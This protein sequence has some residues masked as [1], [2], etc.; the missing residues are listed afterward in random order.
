MQEKSSDDEI[1]I[2]TNKSVKLNSKK[3]GSYMQLWI[4][5]AK[6]SRH[7]IEI[8]FDLLNN[9]LQEFDASIIKGSEKQHYIIT[10][11][12]K[13]VYYDTKKKVMVKEDLVKSHHI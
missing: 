7:D 9:Q 3:L 8:I 1:R 12:L 10:D 13:V 5:K 4:Q 6:H 11:D 2:E